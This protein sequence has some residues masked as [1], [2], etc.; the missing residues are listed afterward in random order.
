MMNKTH[1]H[2]TRREIQVLRL[3]SVGMSHKEI[4]MTEGISFHTV[5]QHVKSILCKLDASN[6]AEL[7]RKAISL[8]Y[9]SI[10]SALK[11]AS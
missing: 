5:R 10:G 6:S 7:V 4:A 9:I 3:V 11:I 1:T 8:K 2:L